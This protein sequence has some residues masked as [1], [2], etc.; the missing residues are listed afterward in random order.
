MQ[1]DHENY[2]EGINFVSQG[3][4]IMDIGDDDSEAVLNAGS[5][6]IMWDTGAGISSAIF[7]VVGTASEVQTALRTIT[8]WE[9]VTVELWGSRALGRTEATQVLSAHQFKVTFPAGY[10]DWG[11]SPTFHTMLNTEGAYAD[12]GNVKARLYDQRFSNSIWLGKTT[13]YFEV[14]MSEAGTSAT[15]KHTALNTAANLAARTLD[16]K[17]QSGNSYYFST[18][19]FG[20]GG[21]TGA[22]MTIGTEI[23]GNSAGGKLHF[24]AGETSTTALEGT[25]PLKNDGGDGG[26]THT[27]YAYLESSK[28]SRQTSDYFAVGST[29]EVLPTTWNTGAPETDVDIKVT[30]NNAYRKFR[31]TG[32]VTNQFNTEFAKLD[33][34]PA[35]DGI[36]PTTALASR[37]DYNLKITSNNGTVHSYSDVA[38]QIT[39]HEVQIL[40]LGDGADGTGA[41]SMAGASSIYKLRYKG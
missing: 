33:S 13:G 36:G 39:L 21:T 22:A 14:L 29:I 38:V 26:G 23:N 16:T 40:S 20:T 35:D 3:Y 30:S 4:F 32:H 2:A 27:R 17:P 19:V 34:F 18:Q 25:F 37:P 6:K 31:V 12:A 28:T 11:K 15:T 8:G 9:A 1:H 5:I 24:K 10:D 41:T 7:A